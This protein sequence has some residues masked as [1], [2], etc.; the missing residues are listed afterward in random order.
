ML[1]CKSFPST[2]LYHRQI[3]KYHSKL[4]VESEFMGDD[5]PTQGFSRLL[6]LF[7]A[8][9]GSLDLQSPFLETPSHAKK[10][11]YFMQHG[12]ADA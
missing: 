9:L 8:S 11:V 12:S 2:P 3:G 6:E 5:L 10:H 1:I 7:N 4:E